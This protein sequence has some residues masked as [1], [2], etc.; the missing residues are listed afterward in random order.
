MPKHTILLPM[1]AA[2]AWGCNGDGKS[3]GPSAPPES[4]TFQGTIAASTNQSGTI[5]ATIG[6]RVSAAV[7]VEVRLVQPAYAQS[8][9]V[10]ATGAV[11]FAGGATTALAG[12]Y[13]TSTKTIVLTGGG[14]TFTGT[15]SST[16]VAGTFNGPSNLSG[17][18][19]ALSTVS[20]TVTRY[21]GTY[22]STAPDVNSPGGTYR[23]SGVW[24]VQVAS[25]GQASGTATSTQTNNSASPPGQTQT[26][27]G[28]VSNGTLSLTAAEGGTATG[29]V[30]STGVSGTTTSKSGKGTGTFSGTMSGCQ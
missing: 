7:P 14:N 11:H 5:D 21:C 16:G 3:G 27:M 10:G 12:T 20:G 17:G 28:Q 2:I 22:A 18:F 13:A 30:T 4:T 29:Q 9:S 23:E 15:V 6:A 24:T 19:S 25:N 26:V 8:T 1:V